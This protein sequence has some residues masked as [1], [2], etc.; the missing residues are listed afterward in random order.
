MSGPAS[1]QSQLIPF[2]DVNSFVID[3]EK[4]EKEAQVV[5][6]RWENR[7][8]TVEPKARVRTYCP[9]CKTDYSDAPFR[10]RTWC[11][12]CINSLDHARDS[13]MRGFFAYECRKKRELNADDMIELWHKQKGRC[14]LT[15]LPLTHTRLS[16]HRFRCLTN[17]LPHRLNTLETRF[18][19]QNAH[20]ICTL[21]FMCQRNQLSTELLL[22]ICRLV[23]QHHQPQKLPAASDAIFDSHFHDIME[24]WSM[25]L[26]TK[27]TKRR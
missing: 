10:L 22:W 1:S 4:L 5:I 9:N 14:A 16:S 3:N 7:W 2:V 18:V 27:Q 20:L 24:I 17:A 15:G 23:V 8:K 26:Q 21:I 11:S 6:D 25:S 12:R 13:Y 19:P